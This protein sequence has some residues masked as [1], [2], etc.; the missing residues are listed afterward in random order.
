MLDAGRAPQRIAGL[1]L[2]FDHADPQRRYVLAETPRL[3][4]NPDP[5]LSL[6]LFRGEQSGGLLQLEATLAPM[7]A[8]LTAVER[9]LTESGRTPTLARPDW[10]SGVVRV[11]GW[12]QT[13]ELAPRL[14]VV[15]P[16]SLVGDPVAVIA[17]RLDAAGAALADAS[18]KGNALPTVVI[19][20]L[21]TLG[22]SGPLGVTAEADLRAIHDRLTAE[23]ALTTPY[24]RARIAKTWESAARDNLIRVRVV[25]ETGEVESQRA[26]AMRRIGEDLLARMFSPFPP[27][28]RPRQLDDGT[29]APLELSFRL[30]MRREELA[31]SERWDFHERRA[32]TIKHYAA[33]SLIDL[34]GAR[35]PAKHITF[36]DL[37]EIQREVVIRAEPELARL[38]LAALE[39]DLRH[40]GAASVH[41][42][43]VLTDARPE[44]RLPTVAEGG[45]LQ[46]R[47][48]AR[49]DPALTRAHDRE[50]DWQ[51]A[52]GGLI[53][54]SA[55][56][57]F[58]PRVFTVLAGRVELD[59][60]D[61]VAVQVEAP[62][63]L[64]RT[65]VLTANAPSADAFLPAAGDRGLT[66]TAEWRGRRDEPTLTEAPREAN[67]DLL[68]LDSPF[69]ESINVLVV[70]LPLSD[71]VTTVVELRTQHGSF[72]HAKTESWDVPDRAPRR[73]GLRRLAG[74]PREF[75]YRVQFIRE[76]GTIDEGP[77]ASSDRST[78]IIGA[79]GPTEVRTTEVVLLGGGPA[80]RGS[81]AVEL[82]LEAGE[83]RTQDLLEG[84]RDSATLA[85]VVPQ[86]SPTPVLSAREFMV[87][88][89]V[90]ETRWNDP[91]AI[92]VLPP[93]PVA[94]P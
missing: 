59:W 63:E 73:V 31:T 6:V 7:E 88:G 94:T 2:F 80:E 56:R 43:V 72:V 13:Q 29:V 70:P 69:A 12:L 76:D 23:G 22:L 19:F 89:E 93:V 55:R 58:P 49:F 52:E 40:A 82:V 37:S 42:T 60:L 20:E 47:V 16:P 27:P 1:T 61:H 75:F 87:S 11:A 71:V 4:A 25:D 26:E 36:A 24:G 21:E 68:V 28:E 91:E 39:V 5:Q 65:L 44:L 64:P 51:E 41:Q 81:V 8:Q 62:E 50:T 35:D 74:S 14:L 15:A 30:T 92:V 79:E 38:G 48:R 57:L 90:H 53:A 85:L 83:H 86:G 84:E 78:L 67:D 10:R 77:W 9:T 46:Y 45:P 18:L 66:V 33:A 54:V 34:L 17:A 32:V 3:V